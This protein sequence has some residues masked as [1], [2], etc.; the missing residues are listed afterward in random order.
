MS[1]DG[2][3]AQ[4]YAIL[5]QQADTA[6][7]EGVTRAGVLGFAEALTQAKASLALYGPVGSAPG[8]AELRDR[9]A[10]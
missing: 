10:A 3:L 2:W 4:K 8:L 7:I 5:A 1:I 6:R 9:L